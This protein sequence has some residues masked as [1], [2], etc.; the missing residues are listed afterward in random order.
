MRKAQQTY[1]KHGSL[2]RIQKTVL[3]IIVIT[4]TNLIKTAEIDNYFPC[5]LSSVLKQNELVITLK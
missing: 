4:A 2:I 1:L 5:Y 3:I